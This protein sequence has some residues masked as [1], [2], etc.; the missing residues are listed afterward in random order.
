MA[1]I[2]TFFRDCKILKSEITLIA[3][4]VIIANIMAV[5]MSLFMYQVA[6]SSEGMFIIDWRVPTIAMSIAANTGIAWGFLSKYFSEWRPEIHEAFKSY[7]MNKKYQ[8]FSDRF[9]SIN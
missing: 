3:K 1:A 4:I 9:N 7:D 5:I 6:N 8:F 2:R